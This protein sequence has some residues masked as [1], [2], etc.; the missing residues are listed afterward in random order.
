MAVR[1]PKDRTD[2]SVR[3]TFPV[4]SFV[5]IVQKTT[6]Q[7]AAFLLDMLLMLARVAAVVTAPMR[8]TRAIVSA[9]S[10]VRTSKLLAVLNRCV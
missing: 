8:A 1:R 9:A 6:A 4:F 5:F 3:V 2:V 10:V 7:I